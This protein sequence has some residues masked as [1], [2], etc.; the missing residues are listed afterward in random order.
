MGESES[1][2]VPRRS[3]RHREQPERLQYGQLG[4]PLL[5]IVQ[6][7]FQG[8]NL[9]FAD[10]LQNH[11]YADT[12]LSNPKANSCGCNGT[13]TPLEGEDVTQVTRPYQVQFQLID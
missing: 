7:L 12:P 3:Q 4:N 5:P 8:L 6:S 2:N 13:Y 11:G 1:D 10:A 9:A